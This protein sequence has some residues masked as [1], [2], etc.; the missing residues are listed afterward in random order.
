MA[1]YLVLEGLDKSF[2]AQPVLRG[3]S[4]AIEKGEILALLGPSGSGK[5][6]ALRMIAGFET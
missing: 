4:L 5:T 6:T 2:G 1:P 3:L